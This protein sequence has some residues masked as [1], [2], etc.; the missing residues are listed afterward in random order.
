[1]NEK[2][3]KRVFFVL[4]LLFLCFIVLMKLSVPY[5]YF[6]WFIREDGPL[7]WVQFL[8]YLSTSLIAF[9]ASLKLYGKKQKFH[10][11][12]YLVFA[13]GTFLISME[14]ISW[15][16]RIFHI[17]TPEK[18]GRVNLQHEFNLHNMLPGKKLHLFFIVTGFYGAF[19]RFLLPG[20][21]KKEH[22]DGVGLLTPAK[23]LFF[24]FFPVFF[25]YFYYD[26]VSRLDLLIFGDNGPFGRGFTRG[27]KA[28][29]PGEFLL[30][31]GF[32]IFTGMNTLRLRASRLVPQK[33]FEFARTD[34]LPACM[35]KDIR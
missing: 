24:Y 5:K 25:F 1:M 27:Y 14:E 9:A 20:R 12:L 8:A 4:P 16:Q 19:L 18:V 23:Y 6:K 3:L 29:E 17:P 7:E 31:M 15:G 32:L 22:P 30:S 34:E 26:Y 28:E 2:S 13:V 21:I 10:A 35:G 33:P 11:F